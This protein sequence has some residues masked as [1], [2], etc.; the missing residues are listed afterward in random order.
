M[1]DR[2][3]PNSTS[4]RVRVCER[5]SISMHADDAKDASDDDIIF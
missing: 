1:I 2:E 4:V 3:N 5:E